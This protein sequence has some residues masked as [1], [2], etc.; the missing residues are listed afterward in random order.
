MGRKWRRRRRVGMKSRGCC[1][2]ECIC[3]CCLKSFMTEMPS[4]KSLDVC[5][6]RLCDAL[7]NLTTV[8]TT[9]VTFREPT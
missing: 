2:R 5:I 3:V 4:M 8:T 1:C 9:Y 7:P 6:P